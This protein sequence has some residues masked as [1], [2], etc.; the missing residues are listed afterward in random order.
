ML[1]RRVAGLEPA[2][3]GP[4]RYALRWDGR[5]AGGNAVASG[6]YVVRVEGPAGVQQQR[7]TLLR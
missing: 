1:G 7:V 4:G 5:S 6:M 3:R 2:P